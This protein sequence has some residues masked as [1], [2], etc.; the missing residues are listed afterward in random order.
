MSK[1]ILRYA[2]LAITPLLSTVA[3]AET[4]ANYF[5]VSSAAIAS[6]RANFN[7]PFAPGMKPQVQ[8][9]INS[10]DPSVS[11]FRVT[12][13]SAAGVSK[14][15]LTDRTGSVS[16]ALIEIDAPD[17]KVTVESLRTIAVAEAKP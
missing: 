12:V 5:N 16:V 13:T 6:L 10:D 14:T 11:G 4:T 1:S 7:L 17:V 2:V 9:F 15:G 8:V 3:S